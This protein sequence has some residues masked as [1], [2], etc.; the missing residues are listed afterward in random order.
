VRR[1]TS[2]A[3]GSRKN[4]AITYW[5]SGKLV[6]GPRSTFFGCW[7]TKAGATMNPSAGTVTR[8]PI[9]AP[10]PSVDASR[11][12]ERGYLSISSSDITGIA[13]PSSSARGAPSVGG[14]GRVSGST[15]TGVE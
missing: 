12:T 2:P 4:V 13:G 1:E 7:L 15:A 3:A 9:S 8:P 6:I 14:A 10:I 11:N 5:F